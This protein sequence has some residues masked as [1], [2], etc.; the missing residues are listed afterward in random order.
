MRVSEAV[1]RQLQ[2]FAWRLALAVSRRPAPL[3][4]PFPVEN[5]GLGRY[6]PVSPQVSPKLALGVGA[7]LSEWS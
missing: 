6:N 3:P 5:S 7:E 1:R 2:L 4:L